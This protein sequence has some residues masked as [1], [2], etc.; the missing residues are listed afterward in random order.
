MNPT[1]EQTYCRFLTAGRKVLKLCVPALLA[2]T[3]LT[4]VA[5]A[6]ATARTP[7]IHKPG[8]PTAVTA[9]A[10]DGGA[11]V[12][13]TAPTSD[14][15]SPITGYSV[16]ASPGGQTCTTT[17]VT[18]CTVTG[19]ANDRSYALHVRASNVAG[20]GRAS[21]VRVSLLPA[22]SFASSVS[23]PYPAEQAVLTLSETTS[24]TVRVD[25]T[26]SDAAG[27]Q[28]FWAAWAGDAGS[29]HPS[30]GTVTFAPGET[31]ATIPFTV[32]PTTASGC[33]VQ[34]MEFGLPCYPAVLVTLVNPRHALL[35]PTP[36]SSLYDVP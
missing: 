21:T 15:G 16:T 6:P 19:L 1:G 30:S 27:A 18:T 13:W 14:G 31:T 4:V 32:D 23:F 10:L 35:G 33:S 17:G 28:L 25:Y 5:S 24:T 12:S 2:V 8:A 34:S 22:V 11:G 36:A 29:F 3:V 7:R 9:T 20:S 26:T